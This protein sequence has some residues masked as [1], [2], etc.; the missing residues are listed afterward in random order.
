VVWP[1][2]DDDLN[3]MKYTRF[4][5]DASNRS[6]VLLW[7]SG[8]TL[9]RLIATASSGGRTKPKEGTPKHDVIVAS[10]GIPSS[11]ARRSEL[12]CL[13]LAQLSHCTANRGQ[14]MLTGKHRN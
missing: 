9:R 13:R 8:L 1:A 7:Y 3:T 11:L 2:R 12:R 5:Y 14:Q 6:C 10:S 4:V